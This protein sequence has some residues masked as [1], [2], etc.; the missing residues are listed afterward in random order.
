MPATDWRLESPARD[1][2]IEWLQHWYDDR[3]ERGRAKYRKPSTQAPV[4]PDV[5]DEYVRP[6]TFIG[7]SSS[8]P[9]GVTAHGT[10]TRSGGGSS[11]PGG[12]GSSLEVVDAE[13]AARIRQMI[14]DKAVRIANVDKAIKR[15]GLIHLNL[16]AVLEMRAARYTWDAICAR[17]D[18]SKPTAYQWYEI[19]L[20]VLA[21]SL[22]VKPDYAATLR[23]DRAAV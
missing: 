9:D 12:R 18:C 15:L 21:F 19:G 6:Q 22:I 8:R 4:S 3:L 13:V 2:A 17:F 11:F 10:E 5:P 23:D 14:A 16:P 7:P 20:G 1:A